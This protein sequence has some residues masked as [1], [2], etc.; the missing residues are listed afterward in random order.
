MFTLTVGVVDFL[1]I[2]AL[3]AVDGMTRRAGKTRQRLLTRYVLPLGVTLYVVTGCLSRWG[4]EHITAA[5]KRPARRWCLLAGR[6]GEPRVQGVAA[7]A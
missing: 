7:A 2:G 1:A 6:L 4:D 5:P 3:L